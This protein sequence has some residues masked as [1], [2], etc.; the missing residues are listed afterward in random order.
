M[1]PKMNSPVVVFVVLAAFMERTQCDLWTELERMGDMQQW[2][3]LCGRYT[4]AQSFME[5]SNARISVFAPV[6]DVFTYNPDLRAMTQ[7]Q[8]LGHIVDT[9]VRNIAENK[10]WEKQTLVRQSVNGGYIYITQFENNPGNFSYFANNGLVCNHASSMWSVI[11]GEQYMFKVCTPMGHRGY[12]STALGFVRDETQGMFVDREYNNE[13]LS[14]MRDILNRAPDVAL[15][16]FGSSAWNS[17]SHLLP[18]E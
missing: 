12:P 7:K 11:S 15:V 3:G 14:E 13:Q 8:A 6:D 2:R 1:G 16:I 17:F 9:Q 18:P 5:D 4:V 10:K